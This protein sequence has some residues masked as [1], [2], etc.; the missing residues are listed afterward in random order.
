LL[1][2]AMAAAVTPG[3]ASRW[4]PVNRFADVPREI[5]LQQAY[6][7]YASPVDQ[8]LKTMLARWA[9]D[10]GMTLSYRHP[11]DFTLHSA[12]AQIRSTR[13]QE[14]LDQLQAAYG[15]RLELSVAQNSISVNAPNSSASSATE[16]A[17]A[18]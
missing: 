11:S 3:C 14:A 16:G 1:L 13:L 17:A 8:T 12:V 9:S 6:V 2:L 10:T 5:P 7:F 18:P 15:G 4:K